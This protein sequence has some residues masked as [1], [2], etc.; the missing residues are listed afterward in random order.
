MK[1]APAAGAPTAT[2]TTAAPAPP[3]PPPS[4][5]IKVVV[6]KRPL[7][8][9]ERAR[10]EADVLDALPGDRTVVVAEPRTRV[11]C[12]RY[13]ELQTFEFDAVLDEG[14]SGDDVYATA[15]APLVRAC[16][17]GGRATVFAYGQTGS[18]KTFTMGKLPERAAA[19]L[20]GRMRGWEEAG[21]GG[22]GEER[23]A[24][25]KEEVRGGGNK[26]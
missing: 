11:D 5:R 13:V 19:E 12:S 15:V 18:G 21:E 16:S 26:K 10:G 23:E 6:R 14:A 25:E 4:P 9:A 24:Q 7:N 20:L 22:E 2:T 8:A 17:K 3:P 1:A